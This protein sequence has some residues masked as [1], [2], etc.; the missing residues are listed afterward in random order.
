MELNNLGRFVELT[1]TSTQGIETALK[2]ALNS[3]PGKVV[4]WY[5]ILET[6]SMMKANA[7][8]YEVKIKARYSVEKV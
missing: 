3:E 6:A 5:E 7:K 8:H 4:D 2:Q 1:G